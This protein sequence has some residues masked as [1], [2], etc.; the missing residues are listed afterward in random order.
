M[1]MCTG[2][3]PRSHTYVFM[4]TKQNVSIRSGVAAQVS[5]F[6]FTVTEFCEAH[7]LSRALLYKLL[8]D[9]Q[10]PRYFKAGRRTLISAESAAQWRAAMEAAQEAA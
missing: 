9:G 5:P 1:L 8:R 6:A 4:T 3:P 2:N 10:G 7:R